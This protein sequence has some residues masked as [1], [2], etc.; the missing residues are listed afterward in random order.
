MK[1][2]LQLYALELENI[3]EFKDKQFN[4][5]EYNTDKKVILW[6][7][8]I[9]KLKEKWTDSEK[10]VKKYEELRCKEVKSLLFDKYLKDLK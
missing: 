6:E 8:E 10:Y 9:I 3:Q 1:P 5:K 4:I 7:Q 2:L